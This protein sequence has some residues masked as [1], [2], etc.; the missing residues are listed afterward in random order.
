M[1][2]RFCFD[3]VL[4]RFCTVIMQGAMRFALQAKESNDVQPAF[5]QMLLTTKET[6]TVVNITMQDFFSPLW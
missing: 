1:E 5:V 6:S 4:E 2:V 3:L